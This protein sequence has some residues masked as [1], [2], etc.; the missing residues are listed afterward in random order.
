MGIVV[1]RFRCLP[2]MLAMVPEPRRTR[3]IHCQCCRQF[4]LALHSGVCPCRIPKLEDPRIAPRQ[5]GP[6]SI[7]KWLSAALDVSAVYAP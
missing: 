1:N 7:E 4:Y 6:G 3:L 5:E 2:P